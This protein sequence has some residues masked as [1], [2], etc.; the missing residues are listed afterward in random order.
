[1]RTE[2]AATTRWAAH[3]RTSDGPNIMPNS[4]LLR[5]G[6]IVPRG[7]CPASFVQV[8]AQQV[9]SIALPRPGRWSWSRSWSRVRGCRCLSLIGCPLRAGGLRC[10]QRREP[11]VHLPPAAQV[12]ADEVVERVVAIGH[13][14]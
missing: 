12:D 9:P 3:L 1:M 14:G 10:G 7:L 6:Q 5:A 13:P 11:A 4:R 8:V 2:I